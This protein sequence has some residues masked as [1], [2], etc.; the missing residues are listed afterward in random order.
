MKL[1]AIFAIFWLL[2]TVIPSW[3]AARHWVGGTAAWD[4]TAGS[5]WSL[6]A[7]GAGG[8]AVPTFSDDV[9]LDSSSGAVTVTVSGA[10]I[11][12]SLNATGFTGTLAGSGLLE[13]Q[14]GSLTLVA[15][16]TFTHTGSWLFDGSASVNVTTAGKTLNAASFGQSGG[17]WTLQDDLVVTNG[18]IF[19]S[20]GTF[21]ANN[22]NVKAATF[23]ASSASTR[24]L[25]MGSGTWEATGTGTVWTTATTTGLTLNANTSTLKLSDSS[26]S[27]RTIAAGSTTIGT[28]N[29][30]LVTAGSSDLTL[31]TV[32][33]N[34]ID[35]TGYTGQLQSSFEATGNV[36]LVSG[37]SLLSSVSLT[38]KG[39][40]GTQTITS[41]G[42]S[43]A[44][45]TLNSAGVTVSLGDDLT[46]AA[47]GS[48]TLND[49][50]TFTLNGHNV[51]GGSSVSINAGTL[52]MGASTWLLN[53]TSSGC[54]WDTSAGVTITASTGT[55]KFQCS[56]GAMRFNGGPF[57]TNLTYPNVWFDNGTD[58][59]TIVVHGGGNTTFADFKDTGTAAHSIEWGVSTTTTFSTFSVSGASS[60]AKIS[61]ISST[62]SV[63]YILSQS[64]GTVTST[65]LDIADSHATGGATWCANSST[66]S[67]GN[68]G[69]TFGC[70]A[71]GGATQTLMMLGVGGWLQD[72][73]RPANDNDVTL[74]NAA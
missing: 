22:H 34:S 41:A 4:A 45:F 1:R 9:F 57:G 49:V 46:L 29:N 72:K 37:M 26:A 27:A 35:F 13:I 7:G 25:T 62:P 61:L 60:G 58:T 8:Q 66:D 50:S 52:T 44:G 30:V 20:G 70:S 12:K 42:K 71:P 51:T 36:T 23:N 33:L 17:T 21:S 38:T 24:T 3:S 59:N 5:K 74:R 39:T 65:F 28:L 10:R 47:I 53:G 56:S 16:M 2:L 32:R 43:W 69:W 67:G 55:I 6:T 48:F 63:F 73:Y 15:G 11:G 68:L 18:W 40:S 14:G 64:T 19:Q 54:T 31:T